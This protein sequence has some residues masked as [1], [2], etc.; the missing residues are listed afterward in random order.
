MDE[1]IQHDI[2]DEEWREYDW[3]FN[4]KKGGDTVIRVYRIENPVTLYTRKNESTHKILD[5]DDIVHCVPSPGR[6]NCALRWK[7][8]TGSD[9]VKF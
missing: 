4:E 7:S 3:V 5:A 1:L 9:P 6:F 2:S 8:R